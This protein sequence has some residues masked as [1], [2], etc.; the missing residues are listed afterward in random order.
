M[1]CART[2]RFNLHSALLLLPAWAPDAD[3]RGEAFPLLGVPHHLLRLWERL[4]ARR[5]R[6][7]RA[8]SQSPTASIGL[9]RG[10][11][12]GAGGS[13]TG[14]AMRRRFAGDADGA[15]V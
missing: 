6:R 2:C 15:D 13:Q 14:S 7:V 5:F 1:A 9:L 3:P 12:R 10:R 4:W 8:R 11:L